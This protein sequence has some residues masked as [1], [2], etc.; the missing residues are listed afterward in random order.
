MKDNNALQIIK[1]LKAEFS[2]VNQTQDDT[3]N[4]SA[5]QFFK[6]LKTIEDQ[7]K[8]DDRLLFK[9]LLG[10]FF[11]EYYEND[12]WEI[13]ERT[14]LNNQ[15]FAQIESWSKLDFKNFLSK[16]YSELE[17]ENSALKKI[18]MHKYKSIFETA[19]NIDYFP[20][21]FDWKSYNEIDFLKNDQ[22]FTPNELKVNH[23][24]INTIFD[25]MIAANSANPKLYF[26]HQKINYNCEFSNCK[27]RF[28]QLEKIV[29][30]EATK[31]DYKVKIISNL[32]E[33][34]QQKNDFKT[35]L[36]WAKNAREMYPDSKFQANISNIENGIKNPN[37][38]LHYEKQT[39]PNKPIHVV[40]EGKNVDKFSLNIYEVKDDLLGFMNFAFDEYRFPFKTVKKTLVRKDQFEL[41]NNDDFKKYKTSLELKPLPSG[42][43]LAEYVVENSVQ[44][45]FYFVVSETKIIFQKKNEILRQ[46]QDDNKKGDLLKLVNNENGKS[47]AN[48]KLELY[49]FVRNGKFTKT[50]VTTDSNGGFRFPENKNNEYYRYYLIKNADGNYNMTDVY[51]RDAYYNPSENDF[52]KQAQIFLDRAIYRPGQTVYF[53]VINTKLESKK[54]IVNTNEE[55]EISL[56]DAN[57]EKVSTQKFKTNDFGSYNGNFI[58]PKGKLNGSFSLRIE[59]PAIESYK[60]FQVEE[61]KRP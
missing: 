59:E 43:Y 27:D 32:M 1:S 46:A 42:I 7:L 12:S 41:K 3:Q 44:T 31:G 54:E 11:S 61:Y 60:D 56:Y 55:Q 17:K 48:Q 14:N 36:V 40:A 16:N 52:K 57:G 50:D 9:V 15:D 18:A 26:E 28:E 53:K 58:L 25:E 30:N 51:G 10:E 33:L 19:E 5:S 34:L 21:L 13:N 24:K 22:L 38:F 39:Q 8:G 49:E 4:D 29:K 35:A 6:K 2:I 47:L 23:S 37:L 20:T 45:S